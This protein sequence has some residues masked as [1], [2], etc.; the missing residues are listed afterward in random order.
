M[1]TQ[2]ALAQADAMGKVPEYIG[3]LGQA[4]AQM[5]G[6]ITYQGT[7]SEGAFGSIVQ[8]IATYA[9]LAAMCWVAREVY[10]PTNPAWLA[11]REWLLTKAPR[12]FRRLYIRHGEW[13]A[14]FISNK[15][16]LKRVIR[17]WMD[18]RIR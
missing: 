17:R 16:R 1:M 11:F 10:G 14:G 12:W 5:R 6:G 9:G 4:E 7:S 8:G 2:G 13:F 3:M 18:S 15:P